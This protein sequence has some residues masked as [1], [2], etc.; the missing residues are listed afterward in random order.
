MGEADA[1]KMAAN[2]SVAYVE[3]VSVVRAIQQSPATWG[4]DR[5]D[6]RNLPLDNS[7]DP[8]AAN[9]TGVTVYVIDTGVRITHNEFKDASGQSR[10]TWG[11]N[12]SGDSK[13]QDC[14]GHGTHV[15]G[16]VGGLKHGVAKNV[17]IIAVKVLECS[18]SG[19][20]AGVVAGVE[21]AMN[22]AA[23]NKISDKA[24][25]NMSLGG[26]FST[27]SNTAVRNLHNSGVLT[28]VGAGNDN[29][30]ACNYSPASEPVAI[31][32]GSTTR[33]DSRSS[34]SNHGSCLDI[35]A[36]GS[37]IT[38][39]WAGSNTATRTMSGTSMASPHVAGGLALTISAGSANAESDVIN[40]ATPGKVS[41]PRA[42]S[43]NLLLYISGTTAPT[44]PTPTARP[45]PTP[46]TRP[47]PTPTAPTPTVPTPTVP[48]PT[49]P[50]P[51]PT[52]PTHDLGC[53]NPTKRR[54]KLEL[55]TDGK[56]AETSF[57]VKRRKNGRF[58][59]RV[60]GG[61]DFSDNSDYTLSRCLKRGKCY[62]LE[63]RDSTGDGICCQ[64]GSG[65]FQGYWN[66]NKVLNQKDVFDSGKISFSKRFGK[67]RI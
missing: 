56:S 55:K 4:I 46:T 7:Y 12:T 2:P 60:F 6:Q 54:F 37:S 21:W 63:V 23:S 57:V 45:T 20:S 1:L 44:A 61:S 15:A 50:S 33:S 36:P 24:V 49:V 26:G 59:V 11:V 18:G 14:H 51:S 52:P 39:A 16:T 42:N 40:A 30:N 25:A 17:N 41:N 32:V 19:T 27:A 48:T 9:G 53:A 13:D 43:P 66:G 47:T 65:S 67:C 35:F 22:H 31:T 64:Y 10:A 29:A 28:V 62:R 34:F 38:A 5:I 8:G 3:Q 58:R